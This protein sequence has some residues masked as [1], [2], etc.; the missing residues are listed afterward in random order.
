MDIVHWRLL[1][2][3]YKSM[4]ATVLLNGEYSELFSVTKGT[5]QGS[6][7]SPYLFNIFIDEL[8]GNLESCPYGIRI[9]SLGLNTAGYA[10]DITLIAGTVT[11]LQQLVNICYHYSCKWRFMFGPSKSKCIKM[12]K[13]ISASTELLDIWLGSNKLEFVNNVEILGRVFSNNLSSQDHIDIRIRNSRRAM[14]SIGLNNQALSPS[15][16]A[17][18]WRS[19]GTPSLMYAIGTCNISPAN[20]KRL[21]SFQGTIIKNS[22]YLGKRCHH[23]ALLEALD[24]PSIKYHIFKQRVGLLKRVWNVITP[25]TKL[26][27]E[28]LALYIAKGIIVKGTL[29]GQLAESGISPLEAIFNSNLP[30]EGPSHDMNPGLVDSIRYVTNAAFYPG[31]ADHTL[32]YNL[33][34]F[35]W[36]SLLIPVSII[37]SLERC[38]SVLSCVRLFIFY[39]WYLAHVYMHILY[40]WCVLC[41]LLCICMFSPVYGG[42]EINK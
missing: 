33:C 16:K 18:L 31:D 30:Y 40:L 20:L 24:I 36:N 14:Y 2:N 6:M 8:M 42:L 12:H 7:L 1:Y 9:G 3:W 21:E 29:V 10:D 25:Y 41:V 15:V 35:G 4:R 28:L 17:Y 27:I 32:L 34:K 39:L 37:W 23:S 19:I 5:R 26:V 22:V 11:D 13:R 38:L